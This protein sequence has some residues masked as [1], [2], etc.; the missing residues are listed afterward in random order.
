MWCESC[1]MTET[2]STYDAKARLSE[3]LRK[4]ESGRTV[5][6]SRHGKAIAEI[7]PIP[8]PAGGLAERIADLTDRGIIVPASKAGDRP[9]PVAKRPGG[10]DRFLADRH[11]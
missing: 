6:I 10:L 5:R 1:L 9:A 2:Y 3:I 4:V 11:R 7:R 8:E